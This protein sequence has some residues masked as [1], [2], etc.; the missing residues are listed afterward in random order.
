ML[1]IELVFAL[2]LTYLPINELLAFGF[3]FE[4]AEPLK[5][6]LFGGG[7]FGID[8]PDKRKREVGRI[9]EALAVDGKCFVQIHATDELLVHDECALGVIG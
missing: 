1:E 6:K 3:G 8:L 7:I 5:D 9:G 2:G 4:S